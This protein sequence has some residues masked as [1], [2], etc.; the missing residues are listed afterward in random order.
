MLDETL[1]LNFPTGNPDPF[2]LVFDGN[3]FAYSNAYSN[4]VKHRSE[5]SIEEFEKHIPMGYRSIIVCKRIMLIDNGFVKHSWN[6]E[7]ST[8]VFFLTCD[9]KIT[10]FVESWQRYLE[11]STI[12]KPDSKDVSH[13]SSK[14]NDYDEAKKYALAFSLENNCRVI[15][16]S[17]LEVL[18]WH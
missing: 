5:L 1:K 8:N 10:K 16:S 15:I 9:K 11:T 6:E 17:E 14:W 7:E 3:F 13:E 12:F 2:D 18:S 4:L